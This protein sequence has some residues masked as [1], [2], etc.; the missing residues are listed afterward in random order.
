MLEQFKVGSNIVVELIKKGVAT[1]QLH[2]VK[3]QQ[4]ESICSNVMATCDV[5]F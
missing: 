3:S 1:L 5:P 2:F 4:H